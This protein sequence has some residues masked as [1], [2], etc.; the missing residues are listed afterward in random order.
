[1]NTLRKQSHF[2]ELDCGEKLHVQ[3]FFTEAS[4]TPVIFLHGSIENGRI[5]YSK[6]NKGLAPFLASAGYNA[7]VIDFRG[8]G[9]SPPKICAQSSYGQTEIITEDIPAIMQFILQRHPMQA[10]HWITHSWGGVLLSSCLARNPSYI[11]HINSTIYYAAKRTIYTSTFKKM[12]MFNLGWCFLAP[13]LAKIVGYLP[14][15]ELR[16]GSDNETRKSLHQCVKWVRRNPWIDSDD[17]FNYGRALQTIM[18]PPTLYLAGSKDRTIANPKDVQSFRAESGNHESEYILLSKQSGYLHDY[19]HIDMLTHQ[20][21][22]KDQYQLTL[23]WMKQH[24]Q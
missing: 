22:S 16:F 18:L 11:S 1:M 15:K 17:N 24:E 7:Y 3:H 4:T 12:I 5:F 2:I 20:D 6:T 10:Q 14:A 23:A 19:G 9:Q 13:I 8:R 21:A